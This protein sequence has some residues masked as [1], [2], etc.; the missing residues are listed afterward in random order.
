MK[1]LNEFFDGLMLG[2]GNLFLGKLAVNSKYQQ[3]SSLIE[4]VSHVKDQFERLGFSFDENIREQV[5]ENRG[6][7]IGYHIRS[8]NDPFSL[9]NEIAGIR[10]G[11]NRFL[12]IS[13]LL[14]LFAFIGT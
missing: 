7:C 13:N 11:L 4:F 5:Q 3:G 8:K 10:Q 12:K 6:H 2:D 14:L 1:Y 9:I